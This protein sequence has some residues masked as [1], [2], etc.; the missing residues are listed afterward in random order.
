MKRGVRIQIM[1]QEAGGF[2]GEYSESGRSVDGPNGS[3]ANG[4]EGKRL[5]DVLLILNC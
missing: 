4:K 2:P 5:K 3:G 1:I